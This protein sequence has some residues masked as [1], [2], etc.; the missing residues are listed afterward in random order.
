MLKTL[1]PL[2]F[3]AFFMQASLS[4]LQCYPDYSLDQ[5]A[6]VFAEFLF[7]KG[8]GEGLAPCREP[9]N[10]RCMSYE[11]NP[12]WNGGVR[13]GFEQQMTCHKVSFFGQW[14]FYDTKTEAKN[15]HKIDSL[16]YFQYNRADVGLA[17]ACFFGLDSFFKPYANFTFAY[18]RENLNLEQPFL[19]CFKGLTSFQGCGATLGISF[20]LPIWYCASLFG[21]ADVAGLYGTHDVKKEETGASCAFNAKKTRFIT[22]MK[23]GIQQQAHLCNRYFFYWQMGWEYITLFDQTNWMANPSPKAENFV[24]QGFFLTTGLH[25]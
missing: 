18:M 21:T 8:Q 22:D 16:F 1:S 24:L 5:E 3:S 10:D 7:L 15:E 9:F 20:N 19:E 11:V 14:T 13:V 4:A 6:H 25:F 23:I 17:K 12:A 2:F